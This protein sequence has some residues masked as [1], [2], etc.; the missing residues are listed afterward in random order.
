MNPDFEQVAKVL[1]K[2]KELID[3]IKTNVYNKSIKEDANP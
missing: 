1:D 2:L 3:F